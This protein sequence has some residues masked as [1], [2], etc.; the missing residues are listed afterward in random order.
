MF[1][2]GT[3]QQ[4]AELARIAHTE[5]KA[6]DP[7]ALL[8]IGGF[9]ATE[10]DWQLAAAHAGALAYADVISFHFGADIPSLAAG[11]FGAYLKELSALIER[12]RKLAANTSAN[13]DPR[14]W[15]TEGGTMDT[16]L[17]TNMP[18]EV[19]L[20]PSQCLSPPS[21]CRGAQAVVQAEAA[22]QYLGLEKH[23]I[24]LQNGEQLTEK[25][26]LY[27]NTDLLDVNNSPRPKLLSRL[28]FAAQTDGAVLPP[29]LLNS[30]TLPGAAL[31][32]FLFIGSH[33]E[34]SLGKVRFKMFIY[35]SFFKI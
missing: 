26:T 12:F 15:N 7:D 8:V 30:T 25:T 22:M 35:L 10:I 23:F 2:A 34:R 9:T 19:G 21:F 32:A 1:F 31:W 11:G 18:L 33:P 13:P 5:L 20:P 28:N 14:L 16:T 4:Y 27:E 6:A 17:L 24:Y 29:R 3:P